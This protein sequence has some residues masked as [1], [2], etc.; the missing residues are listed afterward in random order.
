[1]TAVV[2]VATRRSVARLE[3]K[4][5]SEALAADRRRAAGQCG[6]ILPAVGG[7]C[8]GSQALSRLSE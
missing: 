5:D 6:R 4:A 3:G 7:P 1:M 8:P 2:P